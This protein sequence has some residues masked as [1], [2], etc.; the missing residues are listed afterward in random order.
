MKKKLNCVML[1]DDNEDDNFF[2]K[3]VLRETGITENVKVAESGFEALDFLKNENDIP[4]LIFLDINMPKMNGWEF[5]EEYKKLNEEQKARVV[6]IMLTTS[7]NP[8]DRKKA[9]SISEVNGF[10]TKPLSPEILSAI[11]QRYFSNKL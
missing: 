9:A 1:I 5:L 4:E 2:H 10:E 3:I 11:V 8:A 6:I 7:L